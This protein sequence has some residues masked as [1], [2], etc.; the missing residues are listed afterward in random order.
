MHPLFSSHREVKEKKYE[1]NSKNFL[2]FF[3]VKNNFS[4]K[5][6]VKKL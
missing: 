1:K 6:P 2:C 3:Y 5:K 4:Q